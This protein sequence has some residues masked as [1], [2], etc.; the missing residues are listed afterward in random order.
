M[1]NKIRIIFVLVIAF[2]LVFSAVIAETSPLT[3]DDLVE[4]AKINSID[5][6]VGELNIEIADLDY[7]EAIR[8]S[9][10]NDYEGGTRT[11]RVS[12]YTIVNVDAIKAKTDLMEAK[13]L[14]DFNSDQVAE[15]VLTSYYDIILQR[16]EIA[17][18]KKELEYIQL[19]TDN[20]KK[21]YDLGL[22]SYLDYDEMM[23]DLET[24]IY[25]VEE[26]NLNITSAMLDFE[27]LIGQDI[28]AEF[29]FE[30][31]INI[32]FELFAETDLE[33]ERALANSWDVYKAKQSYEFSQGEFEVV[34][35]YYREEDKEYKEAYLN[36]KSAEYDYR[37]TM[38]DF[39][40]K[41]A[42]LS[43]SLDILIQKIKLYEGY[44]DIAKDEYAI[45]QTKYDLGLISNQD[46]FEKEVEIAQAKYDFDEIIVDYNKTVL[47]INDYTDYMIETYQ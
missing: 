15:D 1:K 31:E 39:E 19:K 21:Q 12:R 27:F 46:L 16:E 5:T 37:D 28:P 35:E 26:L 9:K 3:I 34:A 32:D 11:S 47:E 6:V 2:V 42:Q 43:N 44:Y 30:D 14:K 17:L 13:Y 18:E 29:V 24:Q 4:L 8:Q 40:L 38:G 36:M 10:L 41:Y 7:D 45:N 22:I 33:Y 20:A 23:D 25:L